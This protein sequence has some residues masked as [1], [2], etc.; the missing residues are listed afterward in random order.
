MTAPNVQEVLSL[1]VQ[2]IE[3]DLADNV[4]NRNAAIVEMKEVGSVKASDGG[5]EIQESLEYAENGTYKRYS[6]DEEL[7]IS[8]S[9]VFSA[10]KYPWKQ[11]ALTIQMHGLEMIQNAGK[12]QRFDLMESRIK[13]AK[14]TYENNFHIDFLSAGT[15]SGGKQVG[16]L[17]AMIPLDPASGTYGGIPRASFSFW[18]PQRYRASTDGSAVFSASNIR[19]Y[20]NRLWLRCA[21]YG[22]ETK[23]ILADDTTFELYEESLQALVRI[24]EPDAKLAKMGFNGYAYKNAKVVYTP[25]ITGMPAATMFFVDP[26]VVKLR[27]FKD[28]NLVRLPKRQ[29][30]NQDVELEILAW[31]GNAT[32]SNQ[33]RLGQLNNT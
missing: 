17:Q 10:A 4:T 2:L 7:D 32:C 26:N 22:G 33:R 13:N 18:Q 20:M 1:A 5:P 6:A 14:H 25:V 29:S 3:P 23:V 24:V 16:G 11:V 9:E 21:R 12:S 28:R 30:L 31:A 8:P 27:Y 15:A 19:P